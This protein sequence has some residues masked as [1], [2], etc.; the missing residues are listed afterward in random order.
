MDIY[1]V[2]EACSECPFTRNRPLPRQAWNMVL[3]ALR[4]SGKIL[5]CHCATIARRRGVEL[6]EHVCCRGFYS[7]HGMR[8]AWL[9][10]AQAEGLLHTID[11]GQ[12]PTLKSTGTCIVENNPYE[13]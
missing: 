9:R 2:K 5:E 12:W 10:T 11:G 13:D 7:T 1:V 6:P 8:N 4:T 3:N